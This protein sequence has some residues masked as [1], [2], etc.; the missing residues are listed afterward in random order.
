MHNLV[1]VRMRSCRMT[2][3]IYIYILQVL[4]I[5]IQFQNF[6]YHS[7]ARKDILKLT[8]IILQYVTRNEVAVVSRICGLYTMGYI[9]IL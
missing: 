7:L 1:V 8:C 4:A 6:E 2:S 5:Y 9:N 3:Y